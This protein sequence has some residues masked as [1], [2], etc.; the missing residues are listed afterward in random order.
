MNDFIR[1]GLGSA[2]M[3]SPMAS[4]PIVE[5][6]IRSSG[7]PALPA[8]LSPLAFLLVFGLGL[9]GAP[10]YPAPRSEDAIDVRDNENGGR[11]SFYCLL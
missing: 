6:F 8:E 11:F 3:A 1:W 5:R 7:N 9:A 2:L 10:I 4:R